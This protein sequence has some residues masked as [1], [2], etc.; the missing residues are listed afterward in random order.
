M[1]ALQIQLMPQTPTSRPRSIFLGSLR[2]PKPD[3]GR[4]GEVCSA[5]IAIFDC[6]VDLSLHTSSVADSH[7]LMLGFV[8]AS[9]MFIFLIP[10]RSTAA[11][12]RCRRAMGTI[13]D[14]LLHVH[15]PKTKVCLTWT[16]V[17]SHSGP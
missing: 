3:L 7:E 9:F 14:R 13:S 6:L 5:C 16:G 2:L 1:C 4:I 12:Q 10:R 17:R 11:M 8:S 15:T